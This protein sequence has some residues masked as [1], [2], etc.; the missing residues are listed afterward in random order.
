M[1]YK[2]I[3]VWLLQTNCYIWAFDVK[4]MLVD[5]SFKLQAPP[6]CGQIQSWHGDYSDLD[7]SRRD[8]IHLGL[9]IVAPLGNLIIAAAPGRVIYQ[10]KQIEGG[11][12]LM[13]LHGKDIHG[14]QV[15]SYYAHLLEFKTNKNAVVGRG[16]VIG[17]LGDTGSNM[18]QSRTPH[19]H[20]E[21]LIYP[22]A[23]NKYWL[24]GFWR[25]VTAVSPNFFSYPI[26]ATKDRLINAPTHYPIWNNSI[27]YGDSNW[28]EDKRFNGFTFPLLCSENQRASLLHTE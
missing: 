24:T 17:K 2:L 19:L 6:A 23:E 15:I 10:H 11:N 4:G 27:D 20:F 22:D 8:N 5:E 7:G 21:V 12:S 26:V 18:P 1:K 9:D 16:E 14:N 25:G 28:I 3:L 13:I